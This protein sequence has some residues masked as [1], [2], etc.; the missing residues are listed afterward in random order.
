MRKYREKHGDEVRATLRKSYQ[1][2]R[3]KRLEEKRLEYREDPEK[4]RLKLRLSYEKHKESRAA[5]MKRY[6]ER[7]DKKE[8][9]NILKRSYKA[10]KR[11]AEGRY[12]I[13]DIYALFVAQDGKCLQPCGAD[14]KNNYHIDHIVALSTGGTNWPNNLQLLCPTCNLSKGSKSM[15]EWLAS[16]SRHLEVA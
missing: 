15:S 2:H 7:E 13:K 12:T 14:I 9:I 5:A 16:R 1:K 4:A 8:L 3:D 6:R 10:R 11:S